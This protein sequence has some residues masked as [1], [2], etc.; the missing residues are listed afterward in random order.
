MAIQTW[1]GSDNT[2]GTD[3]DRGNNWLSTSVPVNGDSLHF[4]NKTDTGCTTNCDNQGGKNFVQIVVGGSYAHDVG[5]L[6]APLTCGCD[7]VT[8]RGGNLFLKAARGAALVAGGEN[9]A[10]TN[11]TST[12]S[13][14]DTPDL[15]T[16]AFAS[17]VDGSGHILELE[18]STDGVNGT[19]FFDILTVD[20]GADTITVSPTPADSTTYTYNIYNDWLDTILVHSGRLVLDAASVASR[21]VATVR[22][23]FGYLRVTDGR[24]ITLDVQRDEGGWLRVICASGVDALTTINQNAGIVDIDCAATTWNLDGGK[25]RFGGSGTLTALNMRTASTGFRFIG[26]GTITTIT[27]RGGYWTYGFN[28]TAGGGTVTTANVEAGVFN[29]SNGHGTLTLTNA[30]NV[31]GQDVQIIVDAN[32]TVAIANQ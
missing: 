10:T 8:M 7:L 32:K 13:F 23:F 4:V 22:A 5:T 15:S 1:T 27:Q 26:S 21:A 24:I 16:T 29:A 17:P 6:A 9:Q 14:G 3:F 28:K 30:I 12:V 2:D 18:G 19:A 20:D 31:D 11:A 25:G